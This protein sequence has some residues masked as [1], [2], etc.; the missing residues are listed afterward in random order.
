MPPPSRM[1]STSLPSVLLF[2]N[3]IKLKGVPEFLT[4]KFGEELKQ[5]FPSVSV[6]LVDSDTDP[7][8]RKKHLEE[9]E[10]LVAKPVHFAD[11]VD[12]VPNLKWV[13]F[14]FAGYEPYTDLI[15]K[16]GKVPPYKVTRQGGT[17][18]VAMAEYVL[19][20]II[21]RERKFEEM[22]EDEKVRDWRDNYFS[23]FRVLSQLT[24]GIA[25][26]GDI[27]C[28][29]ARLCKAFG[30]RTIGLVRTPRSQETRSEYIDEYRLTS[31]LPYMLAES[32]VI[33]NILPS[34]PETNNFFNEDAFQHCTKKP[35]FINIG[36]G[37]CVKESTIIKAL[38]N[39]WLSNVI[40]DTTDPEPL[41][42]DS[43][44]WSIPEVTITPH[45]SGYVPQRMMGELFARNY[46]RFIKGESLEYEVDV[47]KL[48]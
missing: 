46:Q 11:I 8:E 40:L 34:L 2:T 44:L 16:T 20:H 9:A 31:D 32:D 35:L 43:Q 5:N 12:N 14:T 25:G 37:D 47:T 41:P 15:K 19:A 38:E 36:R 10:I 42:K 7:S 24:I 18:G 26:A 6:K 13:H 23:Q 30:M 3:D 48:S 21:A 17:F 27:G 39:G 45:I 28:D 33:C 29:V 1:T 22:R 4:E